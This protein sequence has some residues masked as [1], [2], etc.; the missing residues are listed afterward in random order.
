MKY[1]FT[2]IFLCF[3]SFLSCS[4]E[5]SSKVIH[6][7][8]CAM[9]IPYHVILEGKG[10]KEATLLAEEAIHSLF[11]IIDST[12]NRF[13][14]LS[15]L[16]RL[17]NWGNNEPFLCSEELWDMLQQCDHFVSLSDS[18]FDPTVLPLEKVWEKALDE[19]ETPSSDMLEKIQD[20]LGWE[21]LHFL[22]GHRV[23]KEHPLTA[24]DLGALA[25][26]HA[27]DL[28]VERLS[29]LGFPCIWV[30]W[31]G[32]VKT[33][34]LHPEGRP[35]MAGILDPDAPFSEKPLEIIEVKDAALATS[36][37]YLQCWTISS[38]G[39]EK[40]YFHIFD[41]KTMSPLSPSSLASVTVLHESCLVA[42]ALATVILSTKGEEASSLY[43][44]IQTN[45]PT[46]RIWL[47]PH[48]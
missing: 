4:K 41:I 15:E 8:G 26:G 31:G 19:G 40:K 17:N 48:K 18:R 46:A 47:F 35:W 22:E 14:P 13:N 45:F 11:A 20:A 6:L 10:T 42:D 16:S 29:S 43:E 5:P 44:R 9:H 30:E 28:L 36:G 38:H 25:K 37:D 39:K 23:V 27:V 12:Y 21:K 3:F 7:K 32:E 34:G 33:K 2:I 1:F 24:L